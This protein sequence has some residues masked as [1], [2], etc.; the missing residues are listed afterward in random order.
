VKSPVLDSYQFGV[1]CGAENEYIAPHLF[2]QLSH[3]RQRQVAGVTRTACVAVHKQM[4]GF[5]GETFFTLYMNTRFR[6]LWGTKCRVQSFPR[7]HRFNVEALPKMSARTSFAQKAFALAL[8]AGLPVSHAVAQNYMFGQASLQTGMKPSGVAAGDFDSDGRIDLAVSNES[9]NTVSVIL[10][11]SDGTFAAKVDYPVGNAP[12]QIVASD[13]NGDG[14]IDLAIVNSSDNTL[15]LL[16]GAGGRAPL[17]R[18][19]FRVLRTRPR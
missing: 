17:L 19:R 16:L 14:I 3:C 4:I 5:V 15:S 9:D 11:Q 6:L 13:L 1:R 12:S 18:C 7:L 10:A 8:L 2:L